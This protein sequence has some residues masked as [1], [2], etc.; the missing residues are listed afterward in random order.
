MGGEAAW[1][2]SDG[3]KI[4]AEDRLSIKAS[5]MSVISSGGGSVFERYRG[6]NPPM[7]IMAYEHKHVPVIVAAEQSLRMRDDF[8]NNPTALYTANGKRFSISFMY[9]RLQHCNDAAVNDRVSNYS[10]TAPAEFFAEAYATFYEE[11]GT[12]GV[13]D[14]DH[15][16]LIRNA[17]WRD[18]IRSHVHD[19]GHG[20][21]GTG[22][23]PAPGGALQDGDD[24][25][26]RPDGARR[27]RASGN[28]GV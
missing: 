1:A 16:R 2:T 3:S 6:M 15:G 14:A 17:T 13:T 23:A 9:G 18:W 10:L 8:V 22:A 25:G 19:R 11:A 5:L 7:P 27:G 12:P 4:S 21:A 24:H 28:P 20:P 26:A